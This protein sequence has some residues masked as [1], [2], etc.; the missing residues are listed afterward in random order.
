MTKSV[1]TLLATLGILVAVTIPDL[2]SGAWPFAPA[3]VDPRGLLGVLV[4]AADR[5][6]DLGVLRS[7][8]VLAGLLVALAAAVALRTRTLPRWALIGLA[9]VV[10]VLLLLPAVLLQVGLRDATDPWY[11]TNDSTYQ[12]ELAGD[13]ILDGNNPY[14]H[15]YGDSGLERFYPAADDEE[16]A[17]DRA[18]RHHFAY[19]PG[20]A[21][22]AAA[23]RVLP[24]PWDDYRLFVLLATFALLPAALLFPGPLVLRL[25]VGS[26]LAANPLLVHGAWFGTADAPA[27]LA[28]VL[29]FGLLVRGR[30]G[31]AAASLAVALTLKQFALVALPFFAV[32]LLTMRVPRPALYR[33]AAIFG[34]VF[35]AAVLPFLVADPAALWRDTVA[36]GA[37][38]YRIVGYGLSN[39]LVNAGI[40]DDRFGSYPFL[41]LV[42]I[43]WLPVT[44]WLLWAQRRAGTLWSGAA[45]FAISM[46]VLLFISRVF[47]TS[48]LAWPLTGIACAFLLSGSD[49]TSPAPPPPAPSGTAPSG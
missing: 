2:G 28:L 17:F 36:Y 49:R 46:F 19:F 21:L 41:P 45:G 47:Q 4:R 32:M 40:L 39:L 34:G 15:D 29:A 3:S 12:I 44:G 14:G 37:D 6:W 1:W 38:T 33:T 18:A 13:L 7:T 16:A 8:A 25:S 10:C 42:L 23:W 30:L 22:T 11:F 31:W 20:T 24:S 26:A 35:L 43:V 9:G 27:L 5:E 48:Y